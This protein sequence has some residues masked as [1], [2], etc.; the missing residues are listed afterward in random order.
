MQAIVS[1]A[2]AACLC[3]LPAAAQSAVIDFEDVAHNTVLEYSSVTSRGYLVTHGGIDDAFAV[4]YGNAD[5]G[6]TSLSGNGT[7][8]LVAFNTSTITLSRP[9]GAVFD[10]LAFDGGESWIFPDH[11]WAT[12]IRVV[13]QLSGGGSVSAI[14]DLDLH[15]DVLT[16]MQSFKL[17]QGFQDLLSVQFSG[18][19]GTPE[20]SLDNLVVGPDTLPAPAPSALWLT[21]LGLAMLARRRRISNAGDAR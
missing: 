14:F 12:Q 8:R 4:V 6:A 10:L 15:K 9:G 19:G 18:I 1:A 2:L 13:G 21:G 20:F 7:H 5:E 3:V 17:G 16:G 11:L